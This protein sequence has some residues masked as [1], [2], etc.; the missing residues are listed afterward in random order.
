MVSS[1]VQ[2]IHI[3]SKWFCFRLYFNISHTVFVFFITSPTITRV[4]ML[5]SAV[6]VVVASTFLPTTFG[7]AVERVSPRAASTTIPT[8]GNGYT[9][10][11]CYTDAVGSRTLATASFYSDSMTVETCQANCAAYQYFGVEYSR[12]CYCSNEIDNGGTVAANTDCNMPCK[13]NSSEYC[14][15]GN[16][17]QVYQNTMVPTIP[18][19]GSGYSFANCYTDSSSARAL[20]SATYYSSSM[21]VEM[22]QS[23]CALYGYFGVEY[24]QECYCGDKISNS[25]VAAAKTDCNMPCPGNSSE[26]CGAASRIQVYSNNLT[27][28]ATAISGYT[29]NGCYTDSSSSRAMSG[30]STV[31]MSMT[32][33]M[34]A[35]FCSGYSMFGLE[36]GTQVRL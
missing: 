5:P 21:T 30:A 26:L 31:S 4:R 32:V 28:Q 13:G 3:C 15:A 17:V 6:A 33:E 1:N 2:C 23:N 25:N 14:G 10:S 18:S 35:S 27:S 8:A 12:E 11:S 24:G 29:Y 34:C 16:R 19:G 22:C 7:Y 20:T 36:Y 9:F